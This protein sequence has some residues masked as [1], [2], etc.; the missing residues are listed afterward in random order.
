[1]RHGKQTGWVD[2]RLY[3]MMFYVRTSACGMRKE[4]TQV[5]HPR[6]AVSSYVAIVPLHE[7]QKADELW[8]SCSGLPAHNVIAFPPIG[9]QLQAEDLPSATEHVPA[10]ASWPMSLGSIMAHGSIQFTAFFT[11]RSGSQAR[12]S[13]RSQPSRSPSSRRLQIFSSFVE[14]LFTSHSSPH[15]NARHASLAAF[16]G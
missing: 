10:R 12:S 15:M 14:P 13:A 9:L 16:F 5:C 8:L 11:H 4:Q 1:M 7:K 6:A 3:F 2:I